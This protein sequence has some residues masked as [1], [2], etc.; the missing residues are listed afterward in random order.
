MFLRLPN[1]WCPHSQ[2][3]ITNTFVWGTC[4]MYFKRAAHYWCLW[5]FHLSLGYHHLAWN[6][7][8]GCLWMELKCTLMIMFSMLGLQ[9]SLWCFWSWRWIRGS[10]FQGK[11]LGGFA[12][13]GCTLS[14]SLLPDLPLVWN[15]PHYCSF[16][17][18]SSLTMNPD[19][20][21][22]VHLFCQVFF[23]FLSKAN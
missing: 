4:L 20:P 21:S 16:P 7:G 1:H 17:A 14:H 3:L 8:G 5:F 19:K 6:E 9:L 15:E 11:V 10:G 18:E 2:I 12:I 23:F 22:S 13:P